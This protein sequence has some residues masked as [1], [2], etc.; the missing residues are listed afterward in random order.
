MNLL[1]NVL[2]IVLGVVV[3]AAIN[4]LIVIVGPGIIPPPAGVDVSN[5]ESIRDSMHLFEPKHFI[6]PFLAHA[7][8]TFTGSLF[9]SI[10]AAS[11]RSAIGYAVGVVFLAGGIAASFMIPAPYW[12]IVLD[13]LGAYIPMAWIGIKVGQR[14][15]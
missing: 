8:G 4:M 15:R 12:F 9:A 6:A 3:G 1:R 2:A 5:M 14:I 13:L 7:G 11:Y 10:I